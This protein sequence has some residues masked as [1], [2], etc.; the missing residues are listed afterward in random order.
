MPVTAGASRTRTRTL[1][2]ERRQSY[3]RIS[4]AAML[5]ADD[6]NAVAEGWSEVVGDGNRASH[7]WNAVAQD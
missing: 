7:D 4:I 2:G 5:P 3:V 6:W 1:T